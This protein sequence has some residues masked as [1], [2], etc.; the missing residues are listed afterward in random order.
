[1]KFGAMFSN[2]KDKKKQPCK[3][4]STANTK[5]IVLKIDIIDGIDQIYISLQRQIGNESLDIS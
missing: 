5:R 2:M 4:L 3:I 1:M